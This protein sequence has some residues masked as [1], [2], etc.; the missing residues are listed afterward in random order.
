M[1]SGLY[2][3]LPA[4]RDFVAANV[5]RRLLEVWE[6][7]LQASVATSRQTLGEGWRDAYN[8]APIWRFWLGASF[9]GEAVL[10]AYMA[11][12]DGVGRCFPLTI[13][14][15]EGDE[16]LPPPEIDAN[17]AWCEAAEA[18]LLDALNQ[19]ADYESVAA[20]VAAMPPPATLPHASELSGIAQLADGAVVVRDFGDELA[21]AF[22]AARRFGHRQAFAAQ[23][24]W[25]TIGGEGFSPTALVVTGL[26]APTRFADMLT[27]AFEG[28]D[29]A[30]T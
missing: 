29:F 30:A 13:F 14:A 27:G 16:A 15:T 3:K 22:R 23:S 9:C 6:P 28:P 11:S 25:W 5:S 1:P 8:S 2:G 4:K 12:I 7:W 18:I 21:V 26:P 24:F 19:D 17:D 20:A 10:G